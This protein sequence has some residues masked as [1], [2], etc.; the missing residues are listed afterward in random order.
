MYRYAIDIKNLA[1]DLA[2]ANATTIE[3]T[4]KALCN[5]IAYGLEAGT[6]VTR[7]EDYATFEHGLDIDYLN[8]DEYIILKRYLH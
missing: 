8:D 1:N 3:N 6:C 4:L 7:D 2:G 5:A